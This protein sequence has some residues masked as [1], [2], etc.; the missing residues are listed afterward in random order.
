MWRLCYA[1]LLLLAL[2]CS[3]Q[4]PEWNADTPRAPAGGGTTPDPDDTYQH[5]DLIPDVWD[6]LERM[7]E[8]GPPEVSAR[9]HTCAKLPY[10]TLGKV[11]ARF[12]VN[13]Q[14]AD[15]E[16]AGALYRGGAQALGQGNLLARDPERTEM[17]ASSAS[18]LF[19]IFLQAAPEIITA[20]PT[21][22]ACQIG[23]RRA[24]M[25]D[26]SGRCTAQGISCL[27][28]VPADPSHLELCDQMIELASDRIVGR[29]MAV[30]ALLS[31]GHTCE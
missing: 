10:H 27:L 7:V 2:G 6:L 20:M 11:L 18:R 12:G 26:D 15:P 23:T 16:S 24:Q 30:A 5:A 29:R 9:F 4:G 25:F 28:G 19:D 17:T 22:K 21:L 31:A 1:S 14:S 3:S 13:L 8:E